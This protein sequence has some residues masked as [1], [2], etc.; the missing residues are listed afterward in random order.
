[1]AVSDPNPGGPTSLSNIKSPSVKVVKLTS[2]NFTTT[3]TDT[4]VAMLPGDSTIVQIA[5]WVKTALAGGSVATP[6]VALGTASGGTQISSG[7]AVAAGTA[8]TYSIQSGV[9]GL[10]QNYSLPNGLDIPIWV[11]GACATGNPT[12]GEIYLMITYIR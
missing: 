12:S 2:A 5:F 7:S 10:F 4:L 3:N 6:T 9:A 1:V 11:R 8:N